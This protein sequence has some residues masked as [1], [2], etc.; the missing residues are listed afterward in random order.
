MKAPNGPLIL[1]IFCALVCALCWVVVSELTTTTRAVLSG[2]TAAAA[3]GVFIWFARTNRIAIGRGLIALGATAFAAPLAA[4][5]AATNDF[6]FTILA[7]L[8]SPLQLNPFFDETIFF[9][10]TLTAI[11]LGVAI[12]LIIIGGVMHRTPRA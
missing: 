8:D 11:G 9:G 6:L 4:T 7:D 3:T 12:V 5:Q 2:M 1:A 10:W